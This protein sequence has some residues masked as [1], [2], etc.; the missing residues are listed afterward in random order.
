LVIGVSF[1]CGSE[2]CNCVLRRFRV[3]AEDL[4]NIG[5]KPNGVGWLNATFIVLISTSDIPRKGG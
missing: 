3:D 4:Q 1:R 5:G 2:R